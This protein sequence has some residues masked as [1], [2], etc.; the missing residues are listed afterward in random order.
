[1]IGLKLYSH[2]WNSISKFFEY[3][4][5]EIIF[6]NKDNV[7]KESPHFKPLLWIFLDLRFL[8]CKISKWSKLCDCSNTTH[9]LIWSSQSLLLY[10][11]FNFIIQLTSCRSSEIISGHKITRTKIIITFKKYLSKTYKTLIN[12]LLKPNCWYI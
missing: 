12:V 11:K 9:F 3:F 10:N 6:N 4:V 5:T 2:S 8:T 7:D 1:M